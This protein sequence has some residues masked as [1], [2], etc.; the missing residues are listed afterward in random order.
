MPIPLRRLAFGVNPRRTTVR[1]AVL[2]AIS[3]VVFGWVLIPVR[4]EGISMLPTYRSGS[5]HFVNRLSFVSAAPA[6]G[7]IVGIRLSGPHVLYIKR[8]IGLPGEQVAIENGTVLIDGRP[9]DEPYVQHRAPWDVPQTRLGRDEYFLIGD[10][11][12]MQAELHD[13]GKA[14]R[15]RIVGRVVF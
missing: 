8:V 2:A 1:I 12:G 5:L 4:A 15:S 14:S 3:V 11:R 13:F 6:R 9:L 7:D 10:N